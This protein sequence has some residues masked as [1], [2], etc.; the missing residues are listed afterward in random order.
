MMALVGVLLLLGGT[1]E[2]YFLPTGPCPVGVGRGVGGCWLG[3][4]S[5]GVRWGGS[6]WAWAE[7]LWSTGVDAGDSGVRGRHFPS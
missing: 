5:P 3:R 2:E 7:A 4:T 6:V 1:V